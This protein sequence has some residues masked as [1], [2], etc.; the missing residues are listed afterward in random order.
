MLRVALCWIVLLASVGR[1]RSPADAAPIAPSSDFDGVWLGEIAGPNARTTFGLAFTPTPRGRL[2]SVYFPE[3]FLFGAN[4]GEADVREGTFQLPAFGLVMRLE[5]DALRGTFTAARL[6][7]VLRRG[8]V[9]LDEPA[10]AEP[11]AAPAPAWTL[12][13]GAPAWASP[14]VADQTLFIGTTDGKMHAIG[15]DGREQW[16]WTG[17]TAIYG[18]AAVTADGVY[19]VDARNELVALARADGT[20]RWRTPL[21]R[22]AGTGDPSRDPTFNHRTTTPVT[23]GKGIFYV[24]SDDG[25][26]CAIRART[27]RLL[28]RHEIG[29]PVFAPVALAGDDLWV[30]AFDGTLRRL[31]RRTEKETLRVT[32]GGPIVSAPVFVGEMVVVGSRDYTLYGVARS[33][34]TAWRNTY[35]FSWVESTPQLAEGVLYIGGS[36]FRR[37]TALR[38]E[39]GERLWS[40]DVGGLSW[41]TPLVTA[42]TVYAGTTGQAIEGTVISHR[43]GLVALNRQTGALR[44]RHAAPAPAGAPF[45]G[46]A[47]SPALLG[48]LIVGAG[49]DGTLVALPVTAR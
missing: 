21:R 5:G 25:A 31:S 38:P 23:D 9:F 47:G 19:F 13:L 28:W 39:T 29:A 37:V 33:G 40:V 41:G 4:F 49:I 15:A 34:T 1:A 36:D 26:V 6:P 27:G 17:S 11:P 46:F 12:A 2:V 10:G 14:V 7:V 20:L 48:G 30:S 32:L 42:D 45:T 8:G 35:W 24:G 22:Q 18:P 16:T 3:M 44:W 43:G